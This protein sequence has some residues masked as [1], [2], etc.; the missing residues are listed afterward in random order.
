M[1]HLSSWLRPP[2][3]WLLPLAFFCIGLTYL[4]ASPHFESPDSYYHLGVIKWIADHGGALP[5]QSPD[6]D[7]LYA[8]EGSQPPLYYL[9]MTPIWLAVDSSDFAD[10]FQPNPLVIAG[11][12]ARL[13][14]RNQIFYQQPHPP[15]LA[16]ASLALY[17]IRLATLAM[18]AVTIY[19][20]CQAARTL[21]PARNRLAVMAASLAAF[22]PQFLFVSSSINNDNLV[23]ML[24]ALALWQM[25]AM[26]RDGFQARRSV[27]IGLLIALAS[28]A[29]LSGLILGV[30]AVFCGILTVARYKDW[31][32]LRLLLGAI[33]LFWLIISGWWYLR[34][35]ILYGE[36]FG[37]NALIDHFGGRNATLTQLITEEFEGFRI[38]YWGLFGWF[39][40]FT[41]WRH[42]L[43]MD[44]LSALALIGLARHLARNRH[45]RFVMSACATLILLTAAGGA[46]LMWY[47][48]QTPSSQGRLMFPYIAAISLLLALGIAALR[49]PAPLIAI[50]MCVFSIAAPHLYIVPAYDHPPVVER[51]PASA[52]PADLRWGDIS[53]V[54]YALPAPAR[55][56]P[57][58]EIPLTLYWQPLKASDAPH[59]LFISLITAEGE[60]L[61]TIDSF[62]GW[63]ALPTIWWRPAAIYRDDYILQIPQDAIGFSDARLHIGWYPYPDGADIQPLLAS[64]ERADAYTI[65][66]G[67]FVDVD[68]QETL[69]EN[70]TNDGAVFG[71]AIR[72]NAWRFRD[73]HILE[74]EWQLTR[75]IAGD[76]RVFAIA[77]AERYQPDA[78]FEIVA[79]ADDSPPARLDFLKA[80]ERFVTRHKFDLAAGFAGEHSVYVGWYNEGI[81]QRLSAPYPANMLELPNIRFCVAGQ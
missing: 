13:G 4:Y 21:A 48:T 65:P 35:L 23:T 79:Q 51:L 7:H 73:G 6:H 56:T 63:G 67:V 8:H 74:L 30:A 55:W 61:A 2:F 10:F 17:L 25:L 60:A 22:N 11:Q 14:N 66:I 49:L 20:I 68:S 80:G 3:H 50:P 1:R 81:G 52:Q 70:V 71:D 24:A 64:G 32:G 42:Y 27:G 26:L 40:I 77:L 78:P 46:A 16:G 19:A 47:S 72:L 59:A 69:T 36:P 62:P 44:I 31:R 45:D 34:N 38:S 29:K 33:L 57:G 15:N 43:A 9:L 5:V 37:T 41:D 28:L 53:L 18:G 12:P 76:L 58:D 54:G 39:S 75:E